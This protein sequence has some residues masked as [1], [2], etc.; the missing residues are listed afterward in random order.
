LYKLLWNDKQ[1]PCTGKK[2]HEINDKTLGKK[3]II[4]HIMIRINQHTYKNIYV[5]QN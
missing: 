5:I 1:N 3:Y 4:T 2:N